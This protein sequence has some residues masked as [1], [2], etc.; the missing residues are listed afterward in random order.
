[1]MPIHFTTALPT[2]ASGKME[3]WPTS[4]TM[5]NASGKAEPI[6]RD[7]APSWVAYPLR[8]LQRVGLSSLS[9]SQRHLNSRRVADLSDTFLV[10][11]RGTLGDRT[12]FRRTGN[13]Q[14][15]STFLGGL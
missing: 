4:T 1:M 7:T 11:G 5:E 6:S 14:L 12:R 10:G 15:A 3:S 13:L 2:S 9:F 8:S